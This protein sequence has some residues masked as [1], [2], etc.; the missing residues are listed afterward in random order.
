MRRVLIIIIKLLT[1]FV[2]GRIVDKIGFNIFL[3]YWNTISK[4]HLL[5][6]QTK[7]K[8][9]LV[10]CPINM[11]NH[12]YWANSMREIGYEATTIADFANFIASI[13]DF[14]YFLHENDKNFYTKIL[15]RKT[16]ILYELRHSYPQIVHYLAF[17]YLLK[18]YDIAHFGFIG[19]FLGTTN[20]WQHEAILMR[21]FGIKSVIQS[22]GADMYMYSRITDVLLRHTFIGYNEH[23]AKNESIIESKVKYWTLNAD[24]LLP[25]LAIDGI[26]RWSALPYNTLAID[27]KLWRTKTTYSTNDGSNGPVKIIHTPNH[28]YIKGTEYLFRA[29]EELKNEGLQFELILLEKK[30]NIEVRRIMNE[31]ADILAEQF[32]FN[33]Y[34]MS[35]VEGMA[36]GLPVLANLS[37]Q[38]YTRAFRLHSFLNECPVL[39]TPIEIIKENLSLLIKNPS[40]RKELGIAGRNYAEKYHSYSS[41]QYLFQKVYDKIWYNSE[42]DL[43]NMYHPLNP[44]AYNNQSPKIEHPLIENKISAELLVTLNK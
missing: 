17:D 33:A 27:L 19:S 35:G 18:N 38:H 28:R 10:W 9:R 23:F 31:E 25:N 2:G 12:K 15:N 5:I 39:S 29:I 4:G 8:P 26:G 40:L 24:A 20:Y 7:P 3:F 11:I 44:E 43:I 42:V 34:A 37:D 21:K 1:F 32:V 13:D 22:Y 14:D 6:R 16:T 36:S 41:A 30:P